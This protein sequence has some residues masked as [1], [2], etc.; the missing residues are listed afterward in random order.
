MRDANHLIENLIP[1]TSIYSAITTKK[2]KTKPFIS[3]LKKPFNIISMNQIHSDIIHTI[4]SPLNSKKKTIYTCDSLITNHSNLLLLVKFADCLPIL[5]YHPSGWIAAIH[6]GRAGTKQ[7]ILHK[8]LLQL[9]KLTS[10]YSDFHIWFGP[11]LCNNCHEINPTTHE[12]FDLKKENLIQLNDILL[13]EKQFIY[14]K[15]QCTSCTHNNLYSS[16]RA[17]NHTT[18]RNVAGIGLV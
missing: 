5:I 16:Y 3:S 9:T 4:T 6:A 13:L 1:N 15:N 2:T 18:Q 8:T 12:C 14:D 7:Q 10:F 17:N 11:C